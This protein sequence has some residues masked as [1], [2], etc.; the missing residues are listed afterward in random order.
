MASTEG[1]TELCYTF[2]VCFYIFFTFEHG[3]RRPGSA[4]GVGSFDMRPNYD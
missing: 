1:E 4:A 3:E 2:Y